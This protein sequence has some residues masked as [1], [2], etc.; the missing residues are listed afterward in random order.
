M[1]DDTEALS[2]RE[3]AVQATLARQARSLV[4]L[5]TIVDQQEEEIRGL[6]VQL[7]EAARARNQVW[8]RLWRTRHWASVW[9][10]QAKDYRRGLRDN[11]PAEYLTL[12]EQALQFAALRAMAE[13]QRARVLERCPWI[14]LEMLEEQ[15]AALRDELQQRYDE[16]RA[17]AQGGQS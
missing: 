8:E 15:E 4:N 14:T 16:L 17:R 5:R 12:D 6:R 11:Q 3:Q 2:K 10:Q 7:D 13:E 9:K 1:S